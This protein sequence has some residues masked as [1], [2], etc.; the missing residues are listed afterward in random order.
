MRL[1]GSGIEEVKRQMS[2]G[3]SIKGRKEQ[4]Y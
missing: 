4:G 3:I 2:D 1:Q